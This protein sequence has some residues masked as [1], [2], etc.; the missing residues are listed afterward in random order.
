MP[1][2]LRNVLGFAAT[3]IAVLGTVAPTFAATV[4]VTSSADTSIF[5]V[6][7]NYNAG[8]STTFVAGRGNP[9]G[10]N[11]IQHALLKFDLSNAIPA[12]AIVTGVTLQLFETGSAT[13]GT[14]DAFN[15]HRM[16]VD[17]TEGTGIDAN[18][19]P[20]LPGE[21]TWSSRVYNTIPW[22]APGGAPGTDYV[23]TA[24][25]GFLL[26]GGPSYYF[27]SSTAEL[28]ADVQAWLNSPGTN[29]GWLLKVEDESP[30]GTNRRFSSRENPS[31]APKL[32]IDYYVVASSPP[33]LT[34]VVSNDFFVLSFPTEASARY[35]IE[36][37]GSIGAAWVPLTTF[38]AP[39]TPGTNVFADSLT[40]TQAF[41][42]VHSP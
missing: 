10:T 39:N 20:A 32:F 5:S 28:V 29:F 4:A 12:N 14:S 17:W 26:Q 13:L 9:A 37:T 2:K 6:R 23:A 18:G 31:F 8:A 40:T 33:I 1:T 19:S 35:T 38:T 42:H 16:L 30:T 34:G 22:G 21:V 11:S 7:S 15:L 24:S 27:V 25:A 36:R 41:Y 3:W